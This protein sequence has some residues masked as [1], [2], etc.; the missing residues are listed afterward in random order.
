MQAT[1]IEKRRN[2]IE[3]PWEKRGKKRKENV[4]PR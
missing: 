3:I 2:F 1:C 4:L